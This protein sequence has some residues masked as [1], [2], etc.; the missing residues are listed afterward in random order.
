MLRDRLELMDRAD[1][2]KVAESIEIEGLDDPKLAEHVPAHLLEQLREE[3]RWR[4]N[5][6]PTLDA[7]CSKAR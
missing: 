3:S 6:C 7:L 4:A 1:R 5:C 2:N